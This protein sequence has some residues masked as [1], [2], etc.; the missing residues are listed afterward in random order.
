MLLASRSGRPAQLRITEVDY[1]RAALRRG[2]QRFAREPGQNGISLRL[3]A[4]D[5]D[6]Q[7]D[8]VV[9]LR[10]GCADAVLASLLISYLERPER[11]L[12]AA[13]RLLRPQG[14]LVL[15]TLRRDADIS[16]IYKQGLSELPPDRVVALFGPEVERD[17]DSLQRRFLNDASRLLYLEE[18][19]Q[20][21]FRDEAELRD[22]VREAGFDQIEAELCFGEPA[23]VWVVS[24]R[25]P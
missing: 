3:L 17:S 4:A 5:L 11:L 24:A 13:F 21:R 16:R 14:R 8:R 2:A 18:A 6:L 10:P 25:R 7:Q 9:P 15:S 19:G 22:L 23:Q 1:I 12:D 20:F